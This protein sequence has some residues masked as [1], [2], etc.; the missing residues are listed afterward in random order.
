MCFS[1]SPDPPP[2]VPYA[3]EDA[4]KQVKQTT[5]P[6]SSPEGGGPQTPATPSQPSAPSPSKGSSGSKLP[7]MM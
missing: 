4:W 6:A 3:P 7:G 1:S 2:H 5:A